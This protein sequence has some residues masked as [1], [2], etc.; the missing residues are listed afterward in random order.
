MA[1][2]VGQIQ[3]AKPKVLVIWPFRKKSDNHTLVAVV[4]SLSHV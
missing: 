2:F 4:Y 3:P 1:A